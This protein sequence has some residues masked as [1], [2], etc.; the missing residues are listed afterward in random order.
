MNKINI[1]IKECSYC[2]NTEFG[3]GRQIGEGNLLPVKGV[4]K[5]VLNKGTSLY[6][7][8][9]LNCG[10]IVRTYVEKPEIFN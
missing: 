7:T 5:G 10:S 8:V 6:H 3:K 4:L 9:C 1:E 2:G